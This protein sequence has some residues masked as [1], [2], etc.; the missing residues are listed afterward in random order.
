MTDAADAKRDQVVSAALEVF[1]RYGFRRTSMDLI[2]R[3]ARMSR[4][5]VYLHFSSKEDV[6]RAV[7]QRFAGDIVAAAERARRSGRPITD[8][9]YDVLAI[10]VE[11]F[12]GTVEAE[13]RAELFAEAE[14]LVED[15]MVAF[16]AEYLSVVEA[17]LEDAAGELDL[18]GVDLPAGDVAA[19]LVDAVAGIARQKADPAVLRLRLRQLVELAVRGLTG[20]RPAG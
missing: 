14:V 17:A 18:L 9:L 1:G 5:A 6:F 7:A 3:A 11:S 20:S 4:P 12:V 8:R 10:K 19:V 15:V 16:E 13:Y 2:A